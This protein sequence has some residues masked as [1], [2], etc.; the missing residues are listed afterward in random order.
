MAQTVLAFFPQFLLVFV[1]K[2]IQGK[3]SWT[4]VILDN[5]LSSVQQ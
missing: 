3:L 2:G 5:F 1:N 4:S